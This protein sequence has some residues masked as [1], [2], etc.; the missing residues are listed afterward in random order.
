MNTI[1]AIKTRRSCRN[2]KPQQV[3]DEKL[4]KILEAGTYA[5]TGHNTQ[6]PWIVAVQNPKLLSRL[7]RMNL[8]F[9]NIQTGRLPE[10]TPL[11]DDLEERDLSEEE[12]AAKVAEAV[13]AS[14]SVAVNNVDTY[15]GA[16]TIVLV[17]A[18]RDNV[19]SVKD[20][21]LVL[22]TMMLAAHELGV[23]TCWINREDKMFETEQGK[24]L[25][26][27]FG[28]PDNL[29]GIGALALGY[30]N[31]IPKDAKARK[32]DYFRIIR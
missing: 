22:G 10:G 21:S 30:W 17:F 7:R 24:R 15:Y 20:G 14:K 32:K 26:K 6:E 3:E 2:Y 12:V 28:L 31:T 4:V 9:W 29:V 23:G 5:P 19:N 27:S 16:P 25:M 8:H 11:P 18:E 1:E 13:A